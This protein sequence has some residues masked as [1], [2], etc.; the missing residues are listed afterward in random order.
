MTLRLRL[1]VAAGLL[2]AVLGIAGY[3]LI[4]TVETSQLQQ[5]DQELQTA[6]PAAA[7]LGR[8]CSSTRASATFGDS[9]HTQ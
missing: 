4:G 6:L 5:I 9:Q 1:S 7:V 8:P 2:L 3:V